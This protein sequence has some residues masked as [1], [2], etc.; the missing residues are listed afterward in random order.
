MMGDSEVE[1][2]LRRLGRA[3]AFWALVQRGVTVPDARC[4]VVAAAKRLGWVVWDGECPTCGGT[5]QRRCG[6]CCGTGRMA[7]WQEG[8]PSW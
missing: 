5:G 7:T 4:A 6:A 8:A 1:D 3:G 2:L